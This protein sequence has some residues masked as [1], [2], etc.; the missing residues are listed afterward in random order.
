MAGEK[1]GKAYEAFVKL[2][3]ETLQAKRIF[4]GDIFWDEKPEGMTIVPDLTIGENKDELEVVLLVTH[5][6]AAGNSHMKAWR[7]MGELAEAKV[8]LPKVPKVF[9]IAFDAVIKENLKLAQ[10]ASFDGQLIVGDLDYGSELQ[11]WIDEN[12]ERLPKDKDDKVTFLRTES[13][14]NNTIKKLIRSFT[15][16]LEDLLKNQAPKE[17]DALWT[18]ERRRERTTRVPHAHN[19]FIRRG[20]SKLLIFED[21]EQAIKVFSGER[22]KADALPAYAYELGLVGKAMGRAKAMDEEIANAVTLLRADQLRMI[23]KRAPLKEM[24]SWLATLRS[25]PHLKFMGQYVADEH[26]QLCNPEILMLR[27]IDL[28]KDPLAFQ[29]N[30]HVP[31]GWKPE[32]VWLLEILMEIIKYSTGNAAGYGYAQLSRELANPRGPARSLDRKFAEYLL[33]PW[34]HLSEWI[35]RV[36]GKDLP[37]DVIKGISLIISNRI[38]KLT[39]EEIVNNVSKIMTSIQRNI[40][41]AK[42]CTHRS[43]EPLRVLIE[44]SLRHCRLLKLRSCFGERAQLGGQA[45]KTT[46]LQKDKT[47]INWQSCSDSGRDHKKKELC[48]RAVALRYSWDPQAE[49]FIPRPGIEKLILVLDG[50]WRRDDLNALARAGWDEIYYPDEMEELAKA[51]V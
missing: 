6:G 47:I 25:L 35:H 4:K 50:T 20:L 19:S 49:K 3:L 31:D 2:A 34:G 42:L 1:K 26:N 5:S 43:F 45:T 44:M 21:I 7:N 16:D 27:L 41:E 38:S 30:L 40:I 13:K 8:C 23:V 18:L 29:Y 39:W 14:S 36:P 22:V 37:V 51:I 9:N 32:Y 15:D 33:S 17:L 48:G 10:A 24:G 46:V 12:L 28:H 11:S